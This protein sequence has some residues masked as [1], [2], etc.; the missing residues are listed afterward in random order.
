MPSRL[1]PSSAPAGNQASLAGPA[2][3]DPYQ[4]H[5]RAI[6]LLM[7]GFNLR[8][9]NKMHRAFSGDLLLPLVLGELGMQHLC[10][11]LADPAA[12]A[13]VLHR[14]RLPQG[15]MAASVPRETVRRAVHRLVD[16]GWIALPAARSVC[17]T[18]RAVEFIAGAPH[19]EMLDDFLWTTDRIADVIAFA[20]DPKQRDALRA[21]LSRAIATHGDDL[22]A[23]LFSTEFVPPAR[24]GPD[25]D[26]RALE[27]ASVLVQF[28]VRHLYRL[29]EPF[30]GDLI[31]PLLLGEVAHYNIG[32]LAY[33][34]DTGLATLD[35]MFV[36]EPAGRELLQSILRPCNA[37][38]LSVVTG[39]PDSTV[40]RKLDTLVERGWLAVLP[41]GT[42]V[43]TPAPGIQFAAMNAVTMQTFVEADAKMRQIL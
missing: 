23:P 29:K 4:R 33:R 38:S 27:A 32:S 43:L 1:L 18:S 24:V 34:T 25:R 19:R 36:D 7:S 21:D 15:T 17:L 12:D 26:R 28:W 5:H 11:A 39:V 41:N 30:D 3:A 42:Y 40:R 20:D 2:A 10:A 37:H 6:T 16:L 14:L 31:L 13:G 8:C 35:A 9:L 22:A